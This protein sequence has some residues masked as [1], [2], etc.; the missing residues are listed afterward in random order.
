MND[1]EL[2]K[3]GKEIEQ[4]L[5][6]LHKR[7][8]AET[9]ELKKRYRA[10]VKSVDKLCDKNQE[11]TDLCLKVGASIDR[12]ESALYYIPEVF[13][14]WDGFWLTCPPLTLNINT[15]MN[16]K[17]FVE[18]LDEALSW[19]SNEDGMINGSDTFQDVGMMTRNKGLVVRMK[20]GTEFQI[21][22]VKSRWAVH[23]K[24]LYSYL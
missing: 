17:E 5:K 19:A 10:H 23:P 2:I 6:A 12:C 24:P 9:K 20:D 3:E 15:V 16:E 13:E 22:V 1:K 14:G 4:E 11:D 18:Y 7:L 8:K 21:T